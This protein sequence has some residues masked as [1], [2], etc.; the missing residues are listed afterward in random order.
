MRKIHC[1]RHAN[2]DSQPCDEHSAYIGWIE[3]SEKSTAGLDYDVKYQ[4]AQIFHRIELFLHFR[5]V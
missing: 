1:L 2:S 3:I 4:E 5:Y